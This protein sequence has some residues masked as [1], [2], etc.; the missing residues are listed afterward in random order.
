MSTSH[1][2][3]PPERVET[4]RFVLRRWRAADAPRFKAAL[5]ASLAELAPW[6]PWAADEP[7]RVGTM[8][9]S[10]RRTSGWR[11]PQRG[12]GTRPRRG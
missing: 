5:D 3:I 10:I 9:L 8:S 4:A 2:A 6:I 11:Q 7:T 1:P 12:R